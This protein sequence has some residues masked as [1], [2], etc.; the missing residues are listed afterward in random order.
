MA[1]QDSGPDAVTG[2]AAWFRPR[3]LLLHLA[4]VLAVAGTGLLGL[5]QLHAWQFHR[6]DR[7]AEIADRAP[8]ELTGV[9][10]PDD[11]YPAD[12]VGQPV[13]VRGEWVPDSQV[14]VPGREQSGSTGV[15]AL[16]SL[17]VCPPS[18]CLT[19]S[20]A[21]PVVLG[22]S[23]HVP[24]DPPPPQGQVEVTGW[25]QPGE[26]QEVDADP[27][28]EVL[29]SVRIPDLLQRSDRDLY[30][31]Y[32]IMDTP[33]AARGD[34]TPVT[35]ASLPGPP[36]SAG[37][38]NLLYAFQWWIFSAFAVY[39]WWRW[40]RDEMAEARGSSPGAT[41]AEAAQSPIASRV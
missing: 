35:P 33:A 25:L 17:A 6:S 27:E 11:P 10:G 14:Y 37:L 13:R 26:G 15:W 7:A 21:V 1:A 5:W 28:D 34:L 16:A 38:R 40:C 22:W 12:A 4:V 18:G 9:L 2:W 24:R 29:P 32:L 31:A 36:A 41:T 23:R 30:S 3:L 39:L 19:S 20:A 8:A